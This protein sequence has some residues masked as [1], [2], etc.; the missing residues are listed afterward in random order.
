MIISGSHRNQSAS[1]MDV[2]AFERRAR[3]MGYRIIAGVDEAGRGPLAGPVVA[4]AVVLATDMM[5]P[6][7]DDSKRVSPKQRD[8]LY[9]IIKKS[10][11]AFGIG[12]AGVSEIDALNILE[13]TRLA[14]MRA[15]AKLSK[16]PDYLLLDAIVLPALPVKQE[17][18]VKGDRLSHSIAA[19]SIVA[20]VTRDKIMNYWDKRYPQYGW[21]QNKG[22]ATKDHLKAIKIFGP[23]PLHRKTFRGVCDSLELFE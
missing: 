22:Y 18:I 9:P 6:G 13:A 8:N 19:A 7:V 21:S 5:I 4:A 12:L 17:S 20:K 10:A 3:E 15:V 1:I 23:C 16:P 14:M 11:S 2:L